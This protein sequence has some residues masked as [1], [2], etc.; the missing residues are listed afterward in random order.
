MKQLRYTLHSDGSSDRRLLPLLTWLLRQ[1]LPEYAIQPTWADLRR[2]PHPPQGLG[3][4]IARCL[5][6]YP[7]DLL[8]VHRDAENASPD[9]RREEIVQAL[10]SLSGY[11]HTICVVP[12]RMQ[13]AWLLFDEQAIRRAA[14][15]PKGQ[16]NLDLPPLP[17]LETIPDP[18]RTLY[19]ALRAASGL[20]GRRLKAFRDAASA[21]RVVELIE[22]FSPLRMLPAFAM[23]E[24][25]T[26][27][28]LIS[29]GR[30]QGGM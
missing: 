16:I 12:V 26:R 10:Q 24:E 20:Q 9:V 8:F 11:P 17:R 4:R 23:L 22:D 19:Q 29:A 13:E 25:D 27:S 14:G 3:P 6:L 1:H 18:K 7:C 21:Y 2:L 15:N 30:L 28:V 5:D